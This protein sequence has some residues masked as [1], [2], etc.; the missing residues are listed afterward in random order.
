[1]V[2]AAESATSKYACSVGIL[3]DLAKLRISSGRSAL[4]CA[5]SRLQLAPIDG[6]EGR[7]ARGAL[8]SGLI[9]GLTGS[10]ARTG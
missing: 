1:M 10:A 3:Q 9:V 7:L 8:K 6:G 5:D 2:K 4:Y